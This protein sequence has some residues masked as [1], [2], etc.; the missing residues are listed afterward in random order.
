VGGGGGEGGS[1]PSE[2]RRERQGVP[3]RGRA[4]RAGAIMEVPHELHR[5]EKQGMQCKKRGRKGGP[6]LRREGTGRTCHIL[7]RH[8]V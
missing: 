7:V 5:Q 2:A 6:L 1:R 4:A 8:P 3:L